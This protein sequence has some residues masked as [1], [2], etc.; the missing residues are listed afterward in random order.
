MQACK[1]TCIPGKGSLAHGR[2]N[3]ETRGLG[4]SIHG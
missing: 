4:G 2:R 3:E 1:L